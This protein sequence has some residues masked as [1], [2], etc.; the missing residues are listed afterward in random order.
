MEVI[1]THINADFDGLASMLAAKKLYPDAVLAF[2]GGQEKNLRDFFLRSTMYLFQTEKVKNIPL[3]KIRRL[4]LVDIRQPHRIGKFAALCNR[5][6]V[7]VH[8]YDHH[9]A[10]PED[11]H[12]SC[13]KDKAGRCHLNH[14]VPDSTGTGH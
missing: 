7:E 10:S 1:T 2:P 5:D 13:R 11:I 12:R 3:N 14:N 9:P 8:I 6:D 4:I